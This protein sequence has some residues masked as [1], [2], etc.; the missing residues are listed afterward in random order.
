MLEGWICVDCQRRGPPRRGVEWYRDGVLQ[1]PERVFNGV[2]FQAHGPD[3]PRVSRQAILQGPPL[4]AVPPPYPEPGN[5]ALPTMHGA[6]PLDV[7]VF[8]D[9]EEVP[10]PGRPGSGVSSGILGQECWLE[11]RSLKKSVRDALEHQNQS[12]DVGAVKP[13]RPD[14]GQGRADYEWMWPSPYRP[15]CGPVSRDFVI[16]SFRE[17]RDKPVGLEPRSRAEDRLP[18][19]ERNPFLPMAPPVFRGSDE[20]LHSAS[21]ADAGVQR[22]ASSCML[23]PSAPAPSVGALQ[24]LGQLGVSPFGIGAGLQAQQI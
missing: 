16:Q 6:G 5:R 12:F 11:K 18:S 24:P 23:P 9:E 21:P 3:P 4:K 20:F 7:P 14:P 8:G 19:Q 22:P 17:V 13:M 15:P 10:K 1:T 2:E